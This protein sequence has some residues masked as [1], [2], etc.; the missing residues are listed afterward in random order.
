MKNKIISL[1]VV[2]ALKRS[3]RSKWGRLFVLAYLLTKSYKT[4]KQNENNN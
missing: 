2:K 4:S 3:H 1:I